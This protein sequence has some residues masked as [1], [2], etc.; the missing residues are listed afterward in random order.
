MSFW[1]SGLGEK[2]TGNEDDSF[3]STFGIIPNDTTA[4]ALINKIDLK[5]FPD[6]S[7]FYQVY[8]KIVSDEFKNR[9]VFQKLHCF[10]ED[11][12]KKHRALNMLMRLFK[13]SNH[14]PAHNAEPGPEDFS[15]LL[16]TS[17]GIK[18]QEWHLNGK[19]GNWVSEVHKV[20]EKFK[21]ETGQKLEIKTVEIIN[22]QTDDFDDV[23]F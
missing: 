18:I 14:K 3:V 6:G 19:E 23:P 21:V 9:T 2:L 5:S 11:I 7:R 17:C 22:T 1:D 4:I 13:L 20:D 16:G 12:Q 8:W 15:P 10:D